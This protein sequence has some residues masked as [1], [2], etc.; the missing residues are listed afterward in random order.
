MKF[1]EIP[2][3]LKIIVIG[4]NIKESAVFVSFDMFAGDHVLEH[5]R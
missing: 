2:L 5:M 3:F 1:I 4:K